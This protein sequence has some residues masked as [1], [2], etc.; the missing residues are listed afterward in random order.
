MNPVID[1][2]DDTIGFDADWF[3]DLLERE[4]EIIDLVDEAE[5]TEEVNVADSLTMA[6]DMVLGC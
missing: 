4:E 3:V 1:L 6:F 2:V 5:D